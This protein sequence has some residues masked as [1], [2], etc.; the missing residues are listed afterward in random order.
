MPRYAARSSGSTEEA[1]QR[2]RGGAYDHDRDRRAAEVVEPEA[3][4][5]GRSLER[6]RVRDGEG[7]EGGG[8]ELT[9]RIAE[10]ARSPREHERLCR[11]GGD[12]RRPVDRERE[13]ERRERSADGHDQRGDLLAHPPAVGGNGA[14][15]VHRRGPDHP[16]RRASLWPVSSSIA[17]PAPATS[18][19][20]AS[21]RLAEK[22]RRSAVGSRSS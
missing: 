4:R 8:R 2:G 13:P 3:Q 5:V 1:A 12:E 21:R 6:D 9:P 14:A 16:D 22:M 10:P 15:D 11:P 7:E 19:A 20:F 18:A 17:Q